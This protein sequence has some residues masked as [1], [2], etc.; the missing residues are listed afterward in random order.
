MLDDDEVTR[1]ALCPDCSQQPAKHAPHVVVFP[2]PYV[3]ALLD[4]PCEELPKLSLVDVSV[5]FQKHWCGFAEGQLHPKPIVNA[6][7]VYWG[8]NRPDGLEKLEHLLGLNLEHNPLLQSYKT[9]L[10][11]PGMQLV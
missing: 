7:I 10:E 5:S 6:P 9:V 2:V 8:E 1:W 3:D 4:T 11:I